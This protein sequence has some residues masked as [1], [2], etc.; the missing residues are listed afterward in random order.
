M[1]RDWNEEVCNV[2]CRL[3]VNSPH[4]FEFVLELVNSYY[5]R[6]ERW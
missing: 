2:L 5:L 3:T 4:V 1:E 6:E